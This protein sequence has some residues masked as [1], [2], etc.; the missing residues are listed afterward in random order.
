MFIHFATATV[1][2]VVGRRKN[3]TDE[4]KSEDLP[5][6]HYLV[7]RTSR[8]GAQKLSLMLQRT[9]LILW[10]IL[11][12]MLS[13]S[14]AAF[15]ATSDTLRGDSV[16]HLN[17]VVVTA[18]GHSQSAF[19]SA[20]RQIKARIDIEQLPA[21]QVSDVLK[22]LSGVNIKDY[23]GIGGLK[24]VSVRSLG[25]AHTG[26]AYDG[27][28]VADGQNGQIDI[29]RFSLDNVGSIE[30]SNGQDDRIFVPARQL[31]SAA[32]ITIR[33]TKPTFRSRPLNGSISLKGGSFSTF[34]PSLSIA[35]R[36]NDRLSLAVNVDYL[37]SKG[38]YP[39]TLYYGTSS[40]D[41][42]STEH[43]RNSD[44]RNLHTEVT[45][46]GEDSL[47]SGYLK[48]YVY[49]SERGLPGATIFY[50]TTSFSSQRINDRNVFIQGHFERELHPKWRLQLNAKYNYDYTHYKDTAYL[51]SRGYDENHYY[52]HEYYLNVAALYNPINSLAL[53]LST[54]GIINTLDA[55]LYDFARPTRYQSLTAFALKYHNNWLTLIG[56]ALLNVVSDHTHDS[57]EAKNRLRC[58]PYVSASFKP[59]QTADFF[60]RLYYKNIYRLPTFNDLYYGR[61]GNRDLKPETTDQINIGLTYTAPSVS[62]LRS[63][64]LTA[65]VYQ[66]F[67]QDKIV[68]FPTKNIFTWTMLNYGKVSISGLDIA[69]DMDIE[70][71]DEYHLLLAASYTYNYAVNITDSEAPDYKHQIPYTPRI[72]G[73]CNAAIRTPYVNVA[74]SLVWSGARYAV[75][76]NYAENRLP[77]YCDHSLS[78]SHD[79]RFR[80][81]HCL[82]L[83]FDVMNLTDDNYSVV[84]YFPMPGRQFRGTIKY[85]F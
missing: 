23:G 56:S 40:N 8:K 22:F 70:F 60:L 66:N 69:F 83:V 33:T 12:T 1:N 49:N 26:V 29:G 34:N 19:S 13:S 68:A 43:R 41:S 18:D 7:L 78:F 35:G 61:V 50:N 20:P 65:D 30:L 75:N 62:V 59:V 64:T 4:D 11:W 32:L 25:A 28:S 79:F 16:R 17:E 24:T 55:D 36:F 31:A 45:L 81:D 54:D 6:T 77:G 74:Y 52:Q 14:A 37:Y 46:F 5:S 84:R 48:L 73:S 76:Q 51:G 58:S 53:S 3:P 71:Y 21:I 57:S 72:S 2:P 42:S 9:L 80:N 38:D 44:V 15:T 85:T 63:L 39:Y 82:S 10:S 47:Q 27:I 67:V